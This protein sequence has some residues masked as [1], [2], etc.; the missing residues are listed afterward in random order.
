M[1]GTKHRY[2]SGSKRRNAWIYSSPR[3]KALRAKVLSRAEECCERCG[4]I[5]EVQVHHR[6]PVSLGGDIWGL[7]NL[8]AL[9]RSC[10]LEMHRQIE[11]ERLPAWQRRLYELVEKPIPRALQRINTLRRVTQ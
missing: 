6:V 9:C 11:V 8:I 7:D 2:H 5:G 4:S 1:I 3:W 10:H